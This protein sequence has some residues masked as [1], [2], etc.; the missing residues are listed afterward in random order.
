VVSLSLY[1]SALILLSEYLSWKVNTH[2]HTNLPFQSPGLL[3]RFIFFLNEF[4]WNSTFGTVLYAVAMQNLIAAPASRG[5][6][7]PSLFEPRKS[8]G[9]VQHKSDSVTR[10]RCWHA[11]ANP[12]Q[13]REQRCAA[14]SLLIHLTAPADFKR[15]T[16]GGLCAAFKMRIG[17]LEPLISWSLF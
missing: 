14:A 1:K 4:L 15:R 13:R 8:L 3:P 5:S 11:T 9:G 17:R 10:R 7:V 16:K 12:M 2:T 6:H